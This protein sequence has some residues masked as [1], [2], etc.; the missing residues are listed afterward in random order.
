MT[1]YLILLQQNT[2]ELTY[3]EILVFVI[4]IVIIFIFFKV[5]T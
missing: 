4:C 5:K 3:F 1:K 2:L